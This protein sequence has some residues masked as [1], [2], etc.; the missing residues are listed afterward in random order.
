MVVELRLA[1][2]VKHF[3]VSLYNLNILRVLKFTSVEFG[4]DTKHSKKINEI[5]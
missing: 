5:K 1:D 3:S 4:P 2:S